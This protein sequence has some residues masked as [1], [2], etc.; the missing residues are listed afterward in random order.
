MKQRILTTT[1][2][3]FSGAMALVAVLTFG[4][5]GALAAEA[6]ALTVEDAKAVAL[7]KAQV[8]ATDVFI[9]QQSEDWDDGQR[10]YEIEFISGD[11]EY[12]YEIDAETGDILKESTQVLSG[13]KT[14][15]DTGLYLTMD[16]AIEKAT[17]QAG[18]SLAQVSLTDF[19]FDFDDG[20]A[21]YELK[22]TADGQTYKVEM[23]AQTGEILKYEVKTGSKK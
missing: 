15:L 3:F 11:K 20:R 17:A 4:A 16:S 6:T 9:T 18:L 7:A 23:D 2:R 22:F 21:E 10:I 12:E 19:E 8:E 5:G 14:S 1:K 13:G